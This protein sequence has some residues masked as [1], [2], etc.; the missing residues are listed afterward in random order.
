MDYKRFGWLIEQ[1]GILYRPPPRYYRWITRKASLKKLVRM[2]SKA[3]FQQRMAE[4]KETLEQQKEP[5]LKEKAETLKWIAET[6]KSLGIPVTV[7]V[8]EESSDSGAQ[9]KV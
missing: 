2:R 8:P 1:L 6:E 4:Y 9:S 3:I 7:T 5:F